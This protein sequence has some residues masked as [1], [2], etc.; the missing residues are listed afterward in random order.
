MR[1]NGYQV[2]IKDA[3][4]VYKFK[5]MVKKHRRKRNKVVVKVLSHYEEYI[6][7]YQCVMDEVR[8]YMYCNRKTFNELKK[9]IRGAA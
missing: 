4:P 8:C 2:I 1:Y 7:D 6:D 5:L 9:Q 3:Y